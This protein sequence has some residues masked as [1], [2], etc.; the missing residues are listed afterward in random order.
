MQNSLRKRWDTVNDCP[1]TKKQTLLEEHSAW[2]RANSVEVPNYR[3]KFVKLTNGQTEVSITPANRDH[4]ID[5]RMGFNPLLDC[6]RKCRTVEEQEERDKENR[7]RAAK[8]A[9]QGVRYLCKQLFADHMLTFSY[10]EN[11][12]D[13]AKVAADW[14]EFVRLYRLR[15]PDWKYLAVLEKQ[16]RGAYHIHVAVHAKQDIRWLLRCWLLAIGQP[17]EDVRQWL[18]EGVKLGTRSMGAVNVEPPKKRWG[19]NSK[20]WN[21]NKLAGYLTKYIGK[22]F[23]EADKNAKKYWH[24]RNVDKPDIKRFWLKAKTFE[25]AIREAHDLV[26]YTGATSLSM[27]ADSTAGVV[28]ITGETAREKIGQCTSVIADQSP[29]FD[30]LDD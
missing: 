29:E 4:V 18:I 10:R 16:E 25:E 6:S 5:A 11:V 28:W 20:V 21:R 27:W 9:K 14:K 23:E 24:S 2:Q 19:G 26:Y 12:E 7:Q 17:A 13:R 8:R 22:E 1:S 30:F 15:H 3:A